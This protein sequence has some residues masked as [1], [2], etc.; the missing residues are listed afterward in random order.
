MGI[1]LLSLSIM[2]SFKVGESNIQA[3][4][5]R[6]REVGNAFAQQIN[7]DLYNGLERVQSLEKMVYD[8]NGKVKNFKDSAKLLKRSYIDSIELLPHGTIK[9]A[10]PHPYGQVGVQL[11]DSEELGEIL[12]SVV[13]SR[14][15]T[16][17][18]PVVTRSGDRLLIIVD[19]VFLKNTHLWGYVIVTLKVPMVYESSLHSLERVD[20]DYQFYAERSMTNQ[21]LDLIESSL[22]TGQDLKN[23]V[24]R[25]FVIGNRKWKLTLAPKKGWRSSKGLP[26]FILAASISSV[27]M[28]WLV[29]YLKTKERD[30]QLKELAYRDPLTGLYNRRGFIE[31]LDKQLPQASCLTEVFLD[32][33]DF[34]LINDLYGHSTGDLALQHLAAYLKKSFPPNS[35]IGRTG[36]D[37]FSV[38]IVNQDP[39]ESQLMIE[40]A[41]GQ[42]QCFEA[43]ETEVA[44]TISAGFAEYPNQGRGVQDLMAKADEALYAA[45]MAGKNQ[46]FRYQPFM[47]GLSREQ[48]GFNVKQL[49]QGLPGEF[50]IHKAD[51]DQKIIFANE[52]LIQLLGCRDYGDFIDFTKGS[53]KYFVHPD[54][55]KQVEDQI[56]KQIAEQK[57]NR[58]S[59]D[60][61]VIYRVKTKDGQVKRLVDLGRMID[62]SN[63]GKVFFVFLEDQEK[64]AADRK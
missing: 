54:D 29:N 59:Y 10:Y 50:L 52:H 38:A 37:E 33:D 9:Y 40:K 22:P 57:E 48:L 7:R 55:R 53:F 42:K 6:A 58:G 15:L 5:T 39:A 44:F 61:H 1:F 32:L 2:I 4:R 60:V 23:P 31:E 3:K 36:G 17:F 47:A 63:Y 25:T 19:P 30:E 14:K 28:I 35:I 13:N 21:H 34:K 11:E 26:S 56:Q 27:I 20:Y 41:I 64:L 62:N 8:N 16:S 46:A 45:K 49:S 12:H 18:G 43:N 51:G 24:S